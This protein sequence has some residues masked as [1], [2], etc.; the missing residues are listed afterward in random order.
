MEHNAAREH[1]IQRGCGSPSLEA[2]KM[3]LA[4]KH[5]QSDLVRV[6]VLQGAEDLT[7]VVQQSLS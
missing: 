2:F 1:T 7:T 3:Q 5:C 4:E 6:M